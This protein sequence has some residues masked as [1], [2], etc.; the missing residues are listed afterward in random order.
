MTKDE[1]VQWRH[2]S[3]TE[4]VF[5]ILRTARSAYADKLTSG[6][7]LNDDPHDT[8][9]AVGTIQAFDFLLNIQYED[10]T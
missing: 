10:A 8:A 6:A 4:E 7:T 2:N 1:F 3:V 9:K 5:E